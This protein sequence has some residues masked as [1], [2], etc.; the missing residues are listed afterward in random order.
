MSLIENTFEKIKPHFER[1]GKLEALYP[2]FEAAETFMLTSREVTGGKTHIRDFLDSKRLMTMVVLALVPCTFFS[3]YNTGAERMLAMGQTPELLPA[4]LAGLW[5]F[6][7]LYIVTMAVGG[8]WEAI[9]AVVRKHEINEGFLVTGLLFPL[10]LPP[11]LPLWQAAVGISFGVVIGKEVFGGTGMNILNPALT[12]RAFLFFTYPGNMSGDGVWTFV[13]KTKDTLIDGFS[14]ATALAVAASAERGSDIVEVINS[15]GFTWNK[16][17]IGLMPGSLG[18]TST[19]AC[20]IGAII[21]I[22]SRI[23]SYRTMAGCVLG[24][25]SISILMNVLAGRD[26]KPM[27]HIPFHYHLVMGGFAFGLVFMATDPVSSAATDTGKWVYGFLIGVLAII[28]RSINPAY[29]EGMML[30]ILLMNVFAPLIDHYVAKANIKRRLA[31][32]TR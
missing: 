31:R 27:L 1:G 2:A 4:I 8:T 6:L 14:G 18:E 20:L 3:F 19:L 32:G 21:L 28:I 15:A 11:T 17:F 22:I 25:L 5:A 24:G 29:P 30:A 13:N 16:M 23:G 26:S 9:F 10:I 12:A 7:P